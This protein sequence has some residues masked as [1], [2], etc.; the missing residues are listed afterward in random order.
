[1]LVWNHRANLRKGSPLDPPPG[2]GAGSQDSPEQAGGSTRR[3]EADLGPHHTRASWPMDRPEAAYRPGGGS[4]RFY[5]WLAPPYISWDGLWARQQRFPVQVS[6]NISQSTFLYRKPSRHA[7][8][9]I[10]K[11]WQIGHLYVLGQV[12]TRPIE[13]VRVAR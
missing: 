3:A 9:H 5:P 1:M 8:T 2:R 13:P 10:T 12:P 6:E 11:R 7:Q 4:P